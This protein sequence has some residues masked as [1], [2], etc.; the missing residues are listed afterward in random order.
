MTVL[1][2]QQA[3]RRMKADSVNIVLDTKEALRAVDRLLAEYLLALQGI[4]PS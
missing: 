3:V 1:Q 2:Q 4:N